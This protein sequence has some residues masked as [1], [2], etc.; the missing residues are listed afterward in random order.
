MTVSDGW[1]DDHR[2][3]RAIRRMVELAPSTGGLALWVR[4]VD[5]N[6]DPDGPLIA[7]DGATIYYGEQ[8]AG[9]TLPEQIALVAHEVLHIALR[10]PQ[11]LT[12]LR[13]L[14]GDI[15]NDLYNLCADA[16]VNSSLSHLGWLQLPG[17]ATHLDTLLET[18]IGLREDVEKLLLEWDLERL[19]RALDDRQPGPIGASSKGARRGGHGGEGTPR[20][21]EGNGPETPRDDSPRPGRVDGPRSVRARQFGH[22]GL[23]DLLP[24]NEGDKPDGEAEH[25]RDWRERLLRAHLNDGAHS[26]LRALIA[27]LPRV[28]TPWEHILRTRLT[29][30]LSRRRELSWSRPSRSYLANRGRLGNGHRMAWEPGYTGTKAVPRLVLI[31]DASGSIDDAL[32]KR[33]ARE[34]EAITRRLESRIVVIVGDR[35]VSRVEVFEPGRANLRDFRFDGG[36]GTDF[37]PLLEEADKHR[38]DLAVVLTD[39]DGPAHF[40]P[41]WPVLWAVPATSAAADVPFGAKLVLQ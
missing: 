13:R 5:V 30:R 21:A 38:P 22:A 39:L 31:I 15:D 36:G 12:D 16:I 23:R 10:H 9:L 29:R 35:Q 8:F 25:S 6:D 18:T 11:R 27:D 28:R 37:S 24:A 32:L 14:L 40:R 7:T 41:S 2:G 3:A 4:H 34:L 19:Y 1:P 33:F 20:D 17:K 26:M